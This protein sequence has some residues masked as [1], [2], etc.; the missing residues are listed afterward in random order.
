MIVEVAFITACTINNTQKD[1]S[2]AN[3]ILTIMQA[4]N[5]DIISITESKINLRKLMSLQGF[6]EWCGEMKYRYIYVSWSDDLAK[7]GA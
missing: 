5:P 7:G 1:T 3:F 2:R 4:G 6:V